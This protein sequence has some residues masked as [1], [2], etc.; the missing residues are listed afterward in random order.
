MRS[1]THNLKSRA[2]RNAFGSTGLAVKTIFTFTTVFGTVI[3]VA[4]LTKMMRVRCPD[5]DARE[6]FVATHE[7]RSP[8]IR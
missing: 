8:S 5:C 7:K 6:K 2:K 1:A 4:L 3:R